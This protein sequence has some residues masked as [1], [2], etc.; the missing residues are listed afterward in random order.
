[1]SGIAFS[2]FKDQITTLRLSQLVAISQI[3]SLHKI[4]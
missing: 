3:A 1:M 2:Y 4:S